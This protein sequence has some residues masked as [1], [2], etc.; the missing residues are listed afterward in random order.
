MKKV[1]SIFSILL[2]FFL[3]TSKESFAQFKLQIGANTGMNFNIISGSDLDDSMNG[4]GMLIGG[5]VDMSFTPTIGLITNLQFYD[6]RSG[7][8]SIEGTTQNINYTVENS[9]SLAYFVIEP[10]LKIKVPG[11]GFYF[12]TGFGAGFNVEGSTE[13]SVK[14]ANDQIT[15]QDGS[16]KSK[17]SLKETLVRFAI[18]GG[19]G[20]D[21]VLSPLVTLT[22]QLG[23]EY[24][25]T[26]IISDFEARALSIQTTATVKFRL[27]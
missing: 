13:T 5:T 11:S 7:S 2:L 26:K 12:I 4:F 20:Y 3:L 19:A 10:L 17:S 27:I 25:I 21:I 15:F 18:K 14:S 24:G 8:N 22:P 1:L 16:T 9:L 23:F 6:N